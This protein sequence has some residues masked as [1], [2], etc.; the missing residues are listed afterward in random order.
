M[1]I[2]RTL[3]KR[4]KRA[5]DARV[6]WSARAAAIVIDPELEAWVWADSPHVERLVGWAGVSGGLRG[7]LTGERFWENGAPKPHDPKG[8]VERALQRAKKPR[9][10]ALYLRL[11]EQVGFSA[12]ADPAFQKMRSILQ[13]WFSP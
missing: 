7:W 4:D 6:G 11:A 3:R 12:C 5:R 2:V 1:Q 8:A 13:A 9:S 10:S